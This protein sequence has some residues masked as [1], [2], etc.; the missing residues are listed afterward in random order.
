M[1]E[2]LPQNRQFQW[3]VV[4]GRLLILW[5]GIVAVGGVFSIALR[6]VFLGVGIR[7]E[8]DPVPLTLASF[9]GQTILIGGGILWFRAGKAFRIGQWK[10]AVL[11]FVIGYVVS[12]TGAHIAFGKWM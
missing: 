1:S 3:R 11:Q 7:V 4:F 9:C 2:P 6:L 12:A 5:G 10:P 8:D